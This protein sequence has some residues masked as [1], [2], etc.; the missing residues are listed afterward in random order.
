M[1]LVGGGG[2]SWA[3]AKTGKRASEWG[4]GGDGGEEDREAEGSVEMWTT[5]DK[6]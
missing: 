2:R 5:A 1:A 6:E 3:K 4:R